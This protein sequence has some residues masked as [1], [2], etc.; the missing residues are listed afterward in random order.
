[1]IQ[2]SRY[3]RGADL[4]RAQLGTRIGRFPQGKGEYCVGK[5]MEEKIIQMSVRIREILVY[6]H[7]N[8]NAN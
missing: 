2:Q 3:S 4:E 5:V 1:M 7:A 8:K 6:I